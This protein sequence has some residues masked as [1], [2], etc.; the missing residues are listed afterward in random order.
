M[1]NTEW[2]NKRDDPNYVGKY[3]SFLASLPTDTLDFPSAYTEE[4]LSYLECSMVLPDI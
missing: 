1:L 3:D 4:E 2:K